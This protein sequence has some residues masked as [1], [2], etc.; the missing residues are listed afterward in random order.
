MLA[1]YVAVFTDRSNN[2]DWYTRAYYLG[3][4]GY[5]LTTYLGGVLTVKMFSLRAG[6]TYQAAK[7]H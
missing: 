5:F 4:L 1:P 6:V 2:I 3:Y 7:K